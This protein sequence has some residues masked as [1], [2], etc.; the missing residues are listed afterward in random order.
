MF[1]FVLFSSRRTTHTSPANCLHHNQRLSLALFTI[2]FFLNNTTLSPYP[3]NNKQGEEE[4]KRKKD[5]KPQKGIGSNLVRA[6]R[7]PYDQLERTTRDKKPKKTPDTMDA[8]GTGSRS[9]STSSSSLSCSSKRLTDPKQRDAVQWQL[10]TFYVAESGSVSKAEVYAAYLVYCTRNNEEPFSRAVFGR[11]VVCKGRD[12]F[13]ALH[14]HLFIFPTSYL[15]FRR[16]FP[17]Y[18]FIFRSMQ[19]FPP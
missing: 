15:C 3:K 19:P 2:H 10:D 18:L 12:L 13:I 16:V 1:C 8:H 5:Q 4:Q 11:L 7:T 17:C 9:G 6:S 14:F